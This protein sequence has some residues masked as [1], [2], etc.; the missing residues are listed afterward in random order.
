MVKCVIRMTK[1]G[2][3]G[4]IGVEWHHIF[5]KFTLCRVSKNLPVWASQ[6]HYTTIWKGICLLLGGWYTSLGAY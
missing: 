2:S 3:S 5:D 4:I 6:S 1:K